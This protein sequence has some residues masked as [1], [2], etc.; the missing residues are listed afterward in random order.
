ME[1]NKQTIKNNANNTSDSYFVDSSVNSVQSNLES[2][3]FHI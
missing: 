2:Y 1:T 3:I